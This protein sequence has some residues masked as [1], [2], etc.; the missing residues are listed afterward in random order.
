M[1]YDTRMLRA[2]LVCLVVGLWLLGCAP[3]CQVITVP[4]YWTDGTTT[5]MTLTVCGYRVR[6]IR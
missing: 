4:V 1:S 5:P 3:L 6:T 2:A